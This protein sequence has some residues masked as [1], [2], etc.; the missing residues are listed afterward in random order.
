MKELPKA[1]EHKEVEARWYGEWERA[2][3]F[4]VPDSPESPPYC[5]VIPPPNITG[6]LHMG[7]GLNNTLQDVLIRY[8]R[9]DG[10]AALWQ[11]GT[12]HAGIA[13]QNVVERELMKSEKK[14]R[15]Q[16]GREA[17]IERI[18]KW[19]EQ[20]GDRILTQLKALGASCDWQR[21]RFTLDEG[22]SRAVRECF[23]RL[24]DE[25]LIYR[26]KYIVNWC[27]RCH[28]AL[29]DDEVDH[30]DEKGSLWYIRYP[31]RDSG[32]G[33]RDSE[34]IV[35]ATTR[36]ETMLGDTAVA[37]NPKDER[38]AHLVG[39]LVE[40]PETG[41]HIP[42]V[43]DDF[44]D[45]AFG[46]GAVKVTPAHDPNDFQIGE[47]HNL[48]RINVMNEDAT[49]SAEA[50]EKYRGLSRDDCRD[51]IVQ[52]LESQGLLE[53]VEDHL[54][55]VGHCYRCKETIEPWLSDQ[56]FVRMRPLAEKAIR[57]TEDGKVRFHPERWTQFYLQWL[58]NARDWCISR[59]IWWGHRIPVWYC[60]SRDQGPGIGDQEK[61]SG[62]QVPGPG[63]RSSCPPIV[64]REAPTKCPKCGGTELVQ[65]EDVLDTWFSS[66][67]WPFSTLGWPE[68]TAPLA[69]Y[70]PT[71]TLV[72]DR[73]IIYF[74]VARMVMMG[75]AMMGKVPFSDVYIHG[76]ILDEQGRKMSKSLGNGIDPIDVIEKYGAD[77]MRY[78][79]M[80]LSTEG[81]DLKLSESKFEMGRNFC[82]KLWNAARFAMMNLEDMPEKAPAD[83][84]LNLADRW[85]LNRLA[86]VTKDM[87][88]A[89]DDFKFSVAAQ[90]LYQFVWNEFCDWY[91]EAAK[92]HLG[93]GDREPGTGDR[94]NERA[95]T[96]HTL[97]RVL[98][99]ILRLAHPFLPFITEEIWGHLMPGEGMLITSHYPKAEKARFEKEARAFA[100]VVV[101]PVEA[102]RNIRGESN[103][104]PK[105]RIPLAI[106]AF[107]DKHMTKLSEEAPRYVQ[108]LAR[109]D[110]LLSVRAG[111]EPDEVKKAAT[112]V[113]DG[114]T[115]YIPYAG[116]IDI[117]A[118]RARLTKEIAR[119]ESEIEAVGRKLGNESFTA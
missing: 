81:Q 107:Q 50:P 43:A 118:E 114:Q 62:S 115:T 83:K 67:L 36:P 13:T 117:E 29:A 49:M 108:H 6:A 46:T 48:P 11:P 32:S 98:A 14:R 86:H 45:S 9:M 88:A 51:L 37:V 106:A 71:A 30:K 40:L 4:H 80:V 110:E 2:G 10:F 84:F 82:N 119:A 20:Y 104:D 87:R 33:T 96:Q 47:R 99:D 52:E 24:Y 72:T 26:G 91:V 25:G 60:R 58:E 113:T 116:L 100:A 68:E 31:L 19:R 35:V 16:V 75:L 17:L 69:H 78:S 15:Q 77:A 102:I 70:Y 56:W 76:T 66:A 34:Y 65:D 8:K 28:T 93:T 42:I 101:E 39:K 22:L 59:Q 44:V 103:V 3:S 63:S 94:E 109:V 79:L 85:I 21:T 23:V 7:H 53:K 111:H 92:L 90:T 97:K 95:A 61:H 54:H 1:Y 5:I 12:D 74:W 55:A 27:P 41:R 57:A 64:A 105:R 18:W 38:Y 89:L 73:G 112:V